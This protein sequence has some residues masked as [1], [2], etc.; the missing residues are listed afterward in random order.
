MKSLV[1]LALV[2]LASC[3]IALIGG[4]NARDVTILYTYIDEYGEE[5]EAKFEAD[6]LNLAIQ[7]AAPIT[8]PASPVNTLYMQ[9]APLPQLPKLAPAA[10]MYNPTFEAPPAIVQV[11]TIPEPQPP[12][13][14]RYS[15]IMPNPVPASKPKVITPYIS[16][17]DDDSS[18]ETLDI[19]PV[20]APHAQPLAAVRKTMAA[21]NPIPAKPT[22]MIS[23]D[24][25]ED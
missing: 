16:L 14:N 19:V 4:D 24:S 22:F 21:I 1:L 8:A 7:N 11:A 2:G 17:D 12:V 15:Q 9:T 23:D 18:E 13:A 6:Y 3:R 5:I 10:A 20:A 25:D